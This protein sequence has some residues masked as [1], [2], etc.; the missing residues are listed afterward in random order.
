MNWPGRFHRRLPQ[1]GE[2]GY[3]QLPA[4]DVARSGTFYRD[5]FNWSVEVGHAGFEAPG[6]NM[7]RAPRMGTAWDPPRQRLRTLRSRPKR[8]A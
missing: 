2:I 5:V 3:T 7:C 8:L 6:M 1:H 4:L